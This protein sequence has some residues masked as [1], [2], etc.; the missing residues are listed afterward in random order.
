MEAASFGESGAL[1]HAS[2]PTAAAPS[3]ALFYW[4]SRSQLL[5]E[6]RGGGGASHQK[7]LQDSSD[8][9]FRS[10]EGGTGRPSAGETLARARGA[11]APRDPS[12]SRKELEP[13]DGADRLLQPGC[14]RS[15]SPRHPS[16]RHPSLQPP[17]LQPPSLLPPS[18][19]LGA[20]LAAADVR[21]YNLKT[22]QL[23]CFVL[24]FFLQMKFVLPMTSFSAAN[25][26]AQ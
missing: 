23:F 20:P 10:A 14:R 19:T 15:A 26:S 8:Q 21:K 18:R 6:P 7:L 5:G 25:F 2:V 16:P 24:G 13:E 12:V 1:R 4:L 17:S 22:R 3:S 9:I 11:A